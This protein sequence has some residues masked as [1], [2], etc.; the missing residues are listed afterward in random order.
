MKN[1]LL[2]LLI[3][4]AA[5]AQAQTTLKGSVADAKTNEPLVQVYI[6]IENSTLG[7]ATDIN[8]R[9]ELEIPLKTEEI[10]LIV[11][12]LGYTNE[13]KTLVVPFPTDIVFKMSASDKL[14]DEVTV[15]A[16]TYKDQ[17]RSTQMSVE[18]LNRR[19]EITTRPVWRI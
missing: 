5:F 18:R 17:V 9:F 12:Y 10:T 7:A 8:G 6:K 1:K 16:T 15:S 4:F 11:S 2:L 3:F 19:C 14:L 13:I